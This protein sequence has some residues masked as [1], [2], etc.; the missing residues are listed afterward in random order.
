M[1]HRYHFHQ[2]FFIFL[3]FF[4]SSSGFALSQTYDIRIDKFFGNAIHKTNENYPLKGEVTYIGYE[5]L[6]EVVMNWQIDDQEPTSELFDK[7]GLN[8]YIPFR[9]ETESTWLPQEKGIYD[10]RIWFTGLNGQPHDEAASDT[11]R[12]KIEVIDDLPLRNLALLESFSSINCGSCAQV[13]PVLKKL[14]DQYPEDYAMIYYHPLNYEDSPIYEF[15]PSDQETRKALYEVFYTPYSVIGD[16]FS[17]GSQYI[18]DFLMSTEKQKFAGFELSGNWH[19]RAGDQKFTAKITGKSY[20]DLQNQEKSYRLFVAAIKDTVSFDQPPGTNGE[21]QF[22]NVMRFFA[23]DANGIDLTFEEHQDEFELHVERDMQ[24]TI[25]KE[26]HK[27]FAF[28]QEMNSKGIYQVSELEYMFPENDFEEY[29]MG[30]TVSIEHQNTGENV[31]EFY[32]NPA[33]NRI[34]LSIEGRSK[35]K[36]LSVYSINGNLV[37]QFQ[38]T[39]SNATIDISDMSPGI[40]SLVANTGDLMVRK[41]L[42]VVQ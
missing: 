22:Y 34:Y 18:D 40:Y 4:F 26:D 32:P 27:I 21:S 23:P 24:E 19:F 16:L 41:K 25:S 8:P 14:I 35:I 33:R 20:P 2:Y 1:K 17:G 13:T 7:I 28:V 11:A 37:R 31:F 39:S 38:P 10:L 5:T 29:D 3:L 42:I 9:Y 30:G 12:F 36:E 6:G 15:N